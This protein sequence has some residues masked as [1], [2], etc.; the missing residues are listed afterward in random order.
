LTGDSPETI[1]G[2]QGALRRKAMHHPR[3]LSGGIILHASLASAL[4]LL[5]CGPLVRA[6]EAN[7]KSA[8]DEGICVSTYN[9]AQV[10]QQ[11]GD[12]VAASRL[13]EKCSAAACGPDLWRACLAREIQLHSE[14]PSVVLAVSA[15]DGE[16]LV[17]VQVKMD[18]RLLTS[19][20]DGLAL[21]INPGTHAFAFAANDEAFVPQI[22]NLQVGDR[23]HVIAAIGELRTVQAQR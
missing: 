10:R 1:P 4:L 2:A 6:D 22:V 5:V 12:L 23:N 16:P 19:R 18:G 11:S 3:H 21:P 15:H 9:K 17:N 7:R 14:V 8:S 13:Y 20:L